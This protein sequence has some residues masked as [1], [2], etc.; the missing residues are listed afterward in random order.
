MPSWSSFFLA[1]LIRSDCLLAHSGLR[2]PSSTYFMATSTAYETYNVRHPHCTSF[3]E[4]R[5]CRMNELYGRLKR[6]NCRSRRLAAK[7]GLGKIP[8]QL[9]FKL[10]KITRDHR[11]AEI[12]EDRLLRLPVKQ[13]PERS[14]D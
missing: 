11:D 14:F 9:A 1:L 13:K 5:L 2:F 6:S 10:W 4:P 12:R 7:S 8:R 3:A